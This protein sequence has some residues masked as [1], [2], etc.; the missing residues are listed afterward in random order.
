ML[1]NERQLGSDFKTAVIK[2]YLDAY[3]AC[4]ER[5][6]VFSSEYA[7]G[8]S[9]LDFMEPFLADVD[10]KASDL[11]YQHKKVGDKYELVPK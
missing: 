7:L 9:V 2:E 1:K 8:K 10:K 3:S 6:G 11:G 4:R 5:L